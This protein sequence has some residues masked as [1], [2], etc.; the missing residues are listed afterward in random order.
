[1]GE[2]K[3]AVAMSKLDQVIAR[4]EI[5]AVIDRYGILARDDSPWDEVRKSFAT[6]A[7]Y[8]IPGGKQLPPTRLEEVLQGG[9]AEYIRHHVTTCDI[10]FVSATEAL[11]ET[12]FIAITDTAWPDHWGC[13]KDTFK[14]QADGD[15]KIQS[16]RICVDNGVPQGWFMKNYGKWHQLPVHHDVHTL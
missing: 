6:D 9:S 10:K 3:N 12:N 2:T 7:V 13:W 8:Y 4:S 5:K 15:W 14:V 11:V 16:R 1:M